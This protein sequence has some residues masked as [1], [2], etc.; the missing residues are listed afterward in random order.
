MDADTTYPL[1]KLRSAMRA[2]GNTDR[3]DPFVL[4][5][6]D[7]AMYVEDDDNTSAGS[8]AW[9][10]CLRSEGI[11]LYETVHTGPEQAYGTICQYPGWDHP[12]YDESKAYAGFLAGV[13]LG[14]LAAVILLITSFWCWR[15]RRRRRRTNEA[16]TSSN[17]TGR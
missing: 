11:G 12:P 17:Q 8:N 4:G 16:T 13:I 14:S 15:T 6:C 10:D 3:G 2:C 1:L 5:P 7:I 9:L